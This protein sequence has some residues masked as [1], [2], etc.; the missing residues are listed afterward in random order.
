MENYRLNDHSSNVKINENDER[1]MKI[2]VSIVNIMVGFKSVIKYP[3]L[4]IIPIAIQVMFSFLLGFGILLGF[5]F[6]P[7]SSLNVGDTHESDMLFQITLPMIIPM[8]EDMHQSLT[9][10]PSI[11]SESWLLSVF[12]FIIYHV[13]L[14][15]AISIYLG[16][17]KKIFV[18]GSHHKQSFI[19]L[20]AHYFG[21][22]FLFQIFFYL[23]MLA[24]FFLLTNF[25]PV[26]IILLFVSM[27]FSLTP[28]IIVLEDIALGD[29]ISA[30]SKYLK[31]YFIRFIPLALGAL[32]TT[33]VFSTF[34]FNLS[35]AT[36]YYVVLIVYT[37]IGSGYIAAF[38]YLLNRCI[39]GDKVAQDIR[40][41][42]QDPHWKNIMIAILIIILPLLGAKF[43]NGEHVV[44][45]PLK[46]SHTITE[47]IAFQSNW[48]DPFYGSDQSVTTYGFEKNDAF[49]L[50]MPLPDGKS[51]KRGI[52]G[53]G[54]V[55]WK[56]DQEK[57][58]KVG[59]STTYWGEE[60]IV[61]SKF[62]FRLN[63]TSHQGN[64]YYTSANGGFV[65]LLKQYQFDE[66]TNMEIFVMNDGEDVFV[67]QYKERFDPYDVMRVD[68]D[69]SYF[70]PAT[71]EYNPDDYK[72]FWFSKEP[73]TKDRLI[74]FLHAKNKELTHIG[75]GPNYYDYENIVAVFLQEADGDALMQFEEESSYA[76]VKTNISS[77]T[78]DQWIKV[79]NE[80]YGDI[81]LTTFLT[82]INQAN[83][84]EGYEKIGWDD[85]E[86]NEYQLIVPFPNGNIVIHCVRE[87]GNLVE[88][89]IELPSELE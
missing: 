21:R 82:Y 45:L 20:G 11:G 3:F 48:S 31:R 81:D 65:K 66:P 34:L 38:M 1:L 7:A 26:G 76:D 46:K 57:M 25:W 39:K 54:K 12:M 40:F 61:D 14:S 64:F 10:L 42:G 43:A 68:E 70:I 32:F 37:F 79:I 50:T 87:D 4:L 78:A 30:S 5:D 9:F 33:F 53:R 52:Y 28:Y 88:L 71:S 44:V 13:I 62:I 56:V 27:I 2:W 69:A 58:E 49:E 89:E 80:L 18:P 83:M 85:R 77:R 6:Q 16:S 19:Q 73:M 41:Q 55:T 36:K 24:S 84:Y 72:Y 63:R 60:V 29:A 8:I 35:E 22:I 74:D 15:F 59:N 75:G 23:L 17:M 67:F 47:G 86:T 51:G